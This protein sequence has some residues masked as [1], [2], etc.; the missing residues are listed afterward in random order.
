MRKATTFTTAR[1]AAKAFQGKPLTNVAIGMVAVVSRSN[2]DKM[3][4]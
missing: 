1:A 3:V 4:S 2:L